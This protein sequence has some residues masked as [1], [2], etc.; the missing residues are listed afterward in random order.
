MRIM[1]HLKK[2]LVGLSTDC[3]GRKLNG[4]LS[5]TMSCYCRK[6]DNDLSNCPIDEQQRSHYFANSK[7]DPPYASSGEKFKFAGGKKNQN[8]VH[9]QQDSEGVMFCAPILGGRSQSQPTNYSNSRTPDGVHKMYKSHGNIVS[10]SSL[11]YEQQ[12]LKTHRIASA[13]ILKDPCMLCY[14]ISNTL[15]SNNN[16]ESLARCTGSMK[17]STGSCEQ[18]GTCLFEAVTIPSKSQA[19]IMC[20]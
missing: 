7:H 5:D 13:Q 1:S 6:D 17:K 15:K 20:T 11:P 10:S 14:P 8:F 3:S 18:K 2:D 16:G 19:Q 12:H 9:K 4:L